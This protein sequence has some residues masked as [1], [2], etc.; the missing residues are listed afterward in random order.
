MTWT[1]VI[2]EIVNQNK[3]EVWRKQVSTMMLKT[4]WY[5]NVFYKMSCPL[6]PSFLAW[7]SKSTVL[8]LIRNYYISRGLM[9]VPL[10]L[11][12]PVI[13]AFNAYVLNNIHLHLNAC[14]YCNKDWKHQLIFPLY[15]PGELRPIISWCTFPSRIP[16]DVQ[17]KNQTWNL[18]NLS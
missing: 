11:K 9:D 16:L 12:L 4:I 17:T 18:Y 14:I 13:L 8:M 10:N 15:N 1:N 3:S 6:F 5:T 2:M 7:D